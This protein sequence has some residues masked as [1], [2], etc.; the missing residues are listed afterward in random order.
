VC[1]LQQYVAV[2][3]LQLAAMLWT[4]GLEPWWKYGNIETVDLAL[5]SLYAVL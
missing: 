1:W 5:F 4:H 3:L 2:M